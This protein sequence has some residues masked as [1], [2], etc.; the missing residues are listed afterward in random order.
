MSKKGSGLLLGGLIGT[1][2][3]VLGGILLAPKS[4]KETR[5]D[6]V[7]LA[8]KIAKQANISLTETKKRTKEIFGD[9]GE[10]AVDK[11][12]MIR[13]QVITK[14]AALKK[15]GQQIDK[16]KYSGIVDEVVAEF[17]GDLASSK[18][19]ALKLAKQLK[20]DWLRVKRAIA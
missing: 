4:G 16:E 5:K 8:N 15:A 18:G 20:K 17:K 14:L 19:G 7:N 13:S 9:A 11:Y 12:R 1:I 10:V 6:L 2:A 3:G